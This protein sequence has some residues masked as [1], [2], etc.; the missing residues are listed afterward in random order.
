MSPPPWR[1]IAVAIVEQEQPCPANR[2]VSR[3]KHEFGANTA[4]A[5]TTLLELIRDGAVRRTFTGKLVL[6]DSSRWSF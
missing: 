3:L 6:P 1:Q 5:N 2:L 4:Q